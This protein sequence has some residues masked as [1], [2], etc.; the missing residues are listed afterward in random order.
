V[1]PV[2]RAVRPM[3]EPEPERRE[4]PPPEPVA[5]RPV[6]RRPKPER[7]AVDRRAVPSAREAVRRE[8]ERPNR[9]AERRR[10]PPEERRACP[11]P[12]RRERP[13]EPPGR[14]GVASE[15]ERPCRERRD[16][17]RLQLRTYRPTP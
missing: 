9:V 5:V 2:R 15:A 16:R 6:D 12:V 8:R 14:V 17:D 4:P 10:E 7:R 11:M 13:G 3:P 1:R